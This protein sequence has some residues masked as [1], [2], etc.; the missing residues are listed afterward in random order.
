MSKRADEIADQFEQANSELL[1]TVE[2]LTEED[3]QARMDAE[4]WP[5]GV[6]ICHLAEHHALLTELL[7]SV[8]NGQPLP[9]WTPKRLEDLDQLNAEIAARNAGR[10]KEEALSLL[11]RNGA[12][13][14][15]QLRNLS[16]EQ[17][18]RNALLE[19]AGEEFSAQDI[20]QILLIGHIGMHS[21]SIQ[22]AAAPHA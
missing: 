17:L 11:R 20:A 8:A 21:P 9:S 6:G 12:A 4:G 19:A 13:T 16:D 18:D 2:K 5:I 15:E 1:G 14:A 3:L 10:T 7:T 22:R